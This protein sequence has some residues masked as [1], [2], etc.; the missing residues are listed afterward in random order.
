MGLTYYVVAPWGRRDKY[1][2]ATIW[3]EHSTPEDAYKG[4]DLLAEVLSSVALGVAG[5]Y[6]VDEQRQPVPRPA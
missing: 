6:V 2:N 4:R 1:S 5:F 3:S